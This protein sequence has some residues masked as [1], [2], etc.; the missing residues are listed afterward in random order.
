LHT[1]DL[2]NEKELLAL[3]A[4]EDEAAFTKLFNHY[5]NHIYAVATRF[6]GSAIMAEETVQEVFMKI[7]LKKEHLTDIQDFKAYLFIITRNHLYRVLS[8]NAKKYKKDKAYA[9]IR[10]LSQNNAETAVLD[11]EYGLILQQAIDRLPR[12][13]KKVYCLVKE[14]GLKR[15]EA[16]RLLHIHPETIKYHLA[17]AMKSLRSYCLP[18][19]DIYLLILACFSFAFPQ[20][21]FF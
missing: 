11:K 7:W 17:E 2:Y 6:T 19:L 9:A 16:A 1:G 8:S 4:D 21:L 15:E 18:Y 3:V 14:M 10:S 13:Q 5:A 12:Q 20:K